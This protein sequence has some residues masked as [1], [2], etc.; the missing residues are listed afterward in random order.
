MR[1]LVLRGIPLPEVYQVNFVLSLR[2]A[3]NPNSKIRGYGMWRLIILG[4]L[5]WLAIHLL[6]RYL[7]QQS[8]KQSSGNHTTSQDVA[9]VK[10]EVCHVHLP[11]S[12]AYQHND[13]FYCSQ[14]HLEGKTH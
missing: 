11:R 8:T 4:V 7:R 9:M 12:E 13:K 2:F 3:Y 5:V 10:C 6:K 14:A 1:S